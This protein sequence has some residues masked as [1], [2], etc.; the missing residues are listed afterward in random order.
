MA[1]GLIFR[2]GLELRSVLRRVAEAGAS[3]HAI[4]QGYRATGP[5][6][7]AALSFVAA[8]MDSLRKSRS[9]AIRDGLAQAREK[10]RIGGR[11][12]VLP[13]EKRAAAEQMI[14]TRPLSMAE[15]AKAVGVSRSSLYNAKLRG[16]K[17]KQPPTRGG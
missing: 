6:L 5:E 16:R 3:F 13:A 9:D 14:A 11:R 2:D 7:A 15:I 8:A 4:A 12:K 1:S 17:K 10:G